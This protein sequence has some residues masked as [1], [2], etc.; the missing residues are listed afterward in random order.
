[1]MIRSNAYNRNQATTIN[2]V[3]YCT[4]VVLFIKCDSTIILKLQNNH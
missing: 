2:K 3:K 1:M 4:V